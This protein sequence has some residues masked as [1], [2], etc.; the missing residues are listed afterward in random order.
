V[1]EDEQFVYDVSVT[2]AEEGDDRWGGPSV[3]TVGVIDSDDGFTATWDGFVLPEEAEGRRVV[4]SAAPGHE[5]E[6]VVVVGDK[7]FQGFGRF[8]PQD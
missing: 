7:A 8:L 3:V 6:A 2:S 4:L 5:V 1:A